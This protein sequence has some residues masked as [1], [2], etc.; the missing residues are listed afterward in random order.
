M[1]H[2]G[3]KDEGYANG[4]WQ[5]TK[6]EVV[7]RDRKSGLSNGLVRNTPYISEESGIV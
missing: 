3:N 4:L 7:T 5:S 6:Q 1:H 2:S